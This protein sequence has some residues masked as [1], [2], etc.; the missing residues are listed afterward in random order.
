MR[1]TSHRAG[2]KIGHFIFDKITYIEELRCTLIE[3]THEICGASVM[4]IAAD[5]KENLFCLSFKTLPDSSNGAPHI[6][7]HTVLCGSKKFPVKDPFFAMSRR[8]MNT[9]MNA[10]TGADFTCYPAASQVKQD[11]YNLLDVYLD[12][13]FHPKLD[14]K[15]F[16]QEGH[17]LALKDPENIEDSP[18]EFQGIVFNE[19]KGSLSSADSRLWNFL[20]K[21]LVPDLPYSHNFGGDPKE[22]PTL[23]HRQLKDFHKKYYHPSHCLFFFYGSFPLS[24]HLEFLEKNVLQGIEKKPPLPPLPVQKRF[25]SG[26]KA[27]GSYPCSDEDLS[28]KTYIAFSFLTMAIKEQ[29]DL[30]AL[31]LLD[32]ILMDT[33]ASL[34][35]Y[36]MLQSG[37]CRQCHAYLDAEMSEVPYMVVC[38]G[39]EKKY[40]DQLEQV[41]FDT[42]KKIINEGIPRPLIDSSLHQLELSRTEINA[43][44]GPFGLNLFM[45][46]ALMKQHGC[47]PENG[48]RIHTLFD[49]ILQRIKDPGYLPS[50]LQKYFLDNKHYVRTVFSPD[51]GLSEKEH[52][53][54]E[55]WLKEI[56][57]KL[58]LE[59]LKRIKEENEELKKYQEKSDVQ[60]IAKL[61]K[62]NLQDVPKG[63]LEFSLRSESLENLTV[64]HHDVFTNKFLYA[65]LLFDLPKLSLQDLPF[66]QLFSTILC[67]VG[68][69]DR[70]YKAQLANM[71]AHTG[72]IGA[73]VALHQQLQDPALARPTFGLRG[74]SLL[75]NSSHLLQMM[76]EIALCPRLDEKERIKELILQIFTSLQNRLSRHALGYAISEA[77]AGLSNGCF[78]QEN[79]HGITYYKFIHS[80]AKQIDENL[81]NI[82]DQLPAFKD[83][84]L[85]LSGPQ[86][87]ISTENEDYHWL[88]RENFFG[89]ANMTGKSFASWESNFDL[90]RPPAHIGRAIPAAV[91]FNCFAF[92]TIRS[93]HADAPLLSL[94]TELLDHK[95]LHPRIREQ[96]G[97]YGAGATYIGTQGHFYFYS[98]RDPHISQTVQ[99]FEE[100]LRE[101][102][103]GNFSDAE[104]EEAKLSLLQALDSP[105]SP[106][107][108]AI[109]AFAWQ[110]DGKTKEYR[111]RYR[112]KIFSATKEEMKKAVQE[113]LL[114]KKESGRLAAYAGEDLLKQEIPKLKDAGLEIE[115]LP[116]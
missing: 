7:E 103:H 97:A 37:L 6:L 86:L 23:T 25:S 11:F 56:R 46:S 21:Q 5:D 91:A 32:S 54:E 108:Q 82:L 96:G 80:L 36:A 64:Y 57:S 30:L 47:P 85:H 104:L 16:W 73:G 55:N 67:D 87:V 62:I 44:Y 48:L 109:T 81:P 63:C 113:H 111:Q 12:A 15:S 88:R 100:S 106:A 29:E 13:V 31:T 34:L 3:L 38:R 35:R 112:D 77:L 107:F 51:P 45:R 78:V 89:L 105:V 84:T 90:G 19:M 9:F 95:V 114:Q 10:L 18:L 92:S 22:I 70:D 41:F 99:A 98:Y 69:K 71:H 61:P 28:N 68:A 24:G 17:R 75:R 43:D 74:R 93:V 79:M 102:A 33:D 39:S 27:E 52:S 116:I 66:L 65:E 53:E 115:L 58:S 72:G 60:E 83:K 14:I 49:T 50:I 26:K 40:A 94:S 20:M 76:K 1:Y 4:H 8:S 110:R 42:L 2:D 101:I 59:D